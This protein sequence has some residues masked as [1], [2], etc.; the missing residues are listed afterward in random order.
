MPTPTSLSYHFKIVMYPFN[1]FSHQIIDMIMILTVRHWCNGD[2]RLRLDMS[3]T[4][5]AEIFEWLQ[6]S[7]DPCKVPPDM[8]RPMVRA[9]V[10]PL[11]SAVFI[12]CAY[13][14]ATPGYETASITYRI[15]FKS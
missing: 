10:L 12:S 15:L 14:V 1:A 7:S 4:A 2:G 6:H 8:F 3:S 13:L 11:G 9:Q 5:G